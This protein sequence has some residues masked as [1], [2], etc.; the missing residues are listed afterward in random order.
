VS[1]VRSRLGVGAIVAMALWARGATAAP[2]TPTDPANDPALR[3]AGI[4]A[5]HAALV[6][7]RLGSDAPLNLD[8]VSARVADAEQLVSTGRLDE[9]IARLTPSRVPVRRR[10]LR[11]R[12][13]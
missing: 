9:A 7:R 11:R 1:A 10:P 2:P 4:R 6:A 8:D 3:A 13:R 5:Y 12:R